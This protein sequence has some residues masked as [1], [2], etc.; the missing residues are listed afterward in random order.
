MSPY[1]KKASGKTALPNLPEYGLMRGTGAEMSLLK[2][3]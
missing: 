3:V 1:T 2:E